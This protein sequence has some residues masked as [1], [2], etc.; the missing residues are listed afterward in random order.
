M[1]IWKIGRESNA[2][3]EKTNTNLVLHWKEP[4]K[5]ICSYLFSTYQKLK[6]KNY[7][8]KMNEKGMERVW[9]YRLLQTESSAH[10]KKSPHL[11]HVQANEDI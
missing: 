1:N 9:S 5:F 7:H 10:N 4:E 6:M 11:S 8:Q 2:H 3:K